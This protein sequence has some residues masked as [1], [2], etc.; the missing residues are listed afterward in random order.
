MEISSVVSFWIGVSGTLVGIIGTGIA[1][2]QWAVL[3][4]T[5][6][7]KSELQYILA[8]INN[9]ALQKQVSWQNQINTFQPLLPNCR[10]RRLYGPASYKRDADAVNGPRKDVFG[11]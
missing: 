10:R 4:E 8:G 7:R 2:Y 9:A 11:R 3:N 1:I 6:K 5:N